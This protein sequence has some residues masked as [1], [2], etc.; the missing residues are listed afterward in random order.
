MP[1]YTPAV[2]EVVRDLAHRD[3][4][5][6]PLEAV[7][8]DTLAGLVYLRPTTGGCE[9]TTKPNRIQALPSPR[10]LTVQHPS[11]PRTADPA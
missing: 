11:R 6:K 9:W 2:G 7:Y 4:S 3:T 5:G 8:M 1:V 10:F